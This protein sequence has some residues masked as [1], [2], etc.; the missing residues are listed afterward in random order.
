[1]PAVWDKAL[2][3][4]SAVKAVTILDAVRVVVVDTMVEDQE[5]ST[6]T[7]DQ[8]DRVVVDQEPM[9]AIL[10]L[11]VQ[12]EQELFVVR[13]GV[14]VVQMEVVVLQELLVDVLEELHLL[15]VPEELVV[16]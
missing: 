10:Q 16:V 13:L 1:M 14:M 8:A 4:I 12:E 2:T 3:A 15:M 5:A 6:A 9:Q 11:L 7:M